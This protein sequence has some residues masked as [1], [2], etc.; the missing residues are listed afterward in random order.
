MLMQDWIAKYP[1]VQRLLQTEKD[2]VVTP[3]A[4]PLVP[5]S[6]FHACW[7]QRY[8]LQG[9]TPVPVD[10][11]VAWGRWMQAADRQVALTSYGEELVVSTVFLG[12]NHQWQAGQPPWLFQTILC[13]LGEAHDCERYS[14]WADAEAGHARWCAAVR[15]LLHVRWEGSD[16]PPS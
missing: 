1:G 3:E 16:V 11:P 2:V 8:I 12:L 10:D 7:M 4:V 6:A 9:H 15:A 13:G 5:A 14:T